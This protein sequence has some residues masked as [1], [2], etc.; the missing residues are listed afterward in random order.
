MVRFGK[1][2]RKHIA[3][4]T[5]R[6]LRAFL[7]QRLRVTLAYSSS[8]TRYQGNFTVDIHT[9]RISKGT[10]CPYSKITSWNIPFMWCEVV[11]QWT[12]LADVYGMFSGKIDA[13]LIT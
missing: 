1:N 5:K 3:V 13:P 12:D 4:K 11:V 9:T 8:T 2:K 10:V 6:Y 7:E